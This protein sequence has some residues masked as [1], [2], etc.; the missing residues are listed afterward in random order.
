MQ[1]SYKLIITDKKYDRYKKRWPLLFSVSNAIVFIILALQSLSISNQLIF[2]SSIILIGYSIYNWS[3]KK[4]KKI[5]YILVYLLMAVI[6]VSD[7]PYW[8]FQS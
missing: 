8:Y 1:P 3:Y 7:T 5:L 4:R 6:W 2:T